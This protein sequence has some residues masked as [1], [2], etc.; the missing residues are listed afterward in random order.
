M[1]FAILLASLVAADPI[2]QAVAS[3]REHGKAVV[4][5]ETLGSPE[6]V[7]RFYEARELAPAWNGDNANALIRVIE[8][9]DEDGLDPADYHTRAF[10]NLREV[11]AEQ[12]VLLT[13]AFLTLADDFVRGRVHPESLIANWCIPPR[14]FDLPFVLDSALETRSV[15]SVLRTLSPPH[16]E[17][18]ELRRALADF[19]NTAD[20]NSVD[21]GPTLCRGDRGPRVAQLRKRLGATDGD[22]FD[23]ELDALL[24]DFQQ[25]H[26]LNPD[27]VAGADTIAELNVT[28]QQRIEQL[29]LNLER[30]RWMPRALPSRYVL[31]NIAAFELHGFDGGR[32]AVTMRTAVG[33]HY[34][35]TPFLRSEITKIVFNPYWNVPPSIAKKE[36]LPKAE[37][38]PTYLQREHMHLLPGGQLQQD[39][40]PWNALGRMKF[41]M[42]NPYA[43]YL[44]DTPSKL[45][46]EKDA[47]AVSHGCIRVERPADLAAW[48]LQGKMDSAAIAKAV[49]SGRNEHVPLPEPVR[50]YVLYWTAIAGDDGEVQFRRD[51][52]DRDA[53]LAAALKR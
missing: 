50:V 24:R 18:R 23:A 38:D 39:P 17:Y 48:L 26:G 9:V 27:G 43:V 5:G 11:S 29:I 35:K 12:D 7:A 3:A 53:E 15:D 32:E 36:L 2:E 30:W 13:D 44:H 51:I 20:W 21:G 49:G 19:R 40:G 8:R 31:V 14:R 37:K 52:Y 33:K 42:P 16:E 41:D 6:D 25:H 22:G 1:I 10:V 46:F 28:R 47:R 4:A 34:T 45:V